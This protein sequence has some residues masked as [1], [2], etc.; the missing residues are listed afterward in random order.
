MGTQ[1]KSENELDKPSEKSLQIG[2]GLTL[3]STRSMQVSLEAVRC[4]KAGLDA[5]RLRMLTRVPETGDWARFDQNSIELKDLAYLTAKVGDEFAL[6][7]GKH[8]DILFHGGRI[9]CHI[10]G[11]L[12][13]SLANRKLELVGHSHP[14]EDIPEPSLGDRLALRKIGQKKSMVISARTGISVEFG[15]DRYEL[16]G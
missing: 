9:E 4:G 5:H 14:G 3:S 15:P 6:L 12:W 16:R 2:N 1:D 7:R 10:T 13:D 8:E 11:I